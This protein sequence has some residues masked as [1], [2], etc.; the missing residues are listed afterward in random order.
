MKLQYEVC[1]SNNLRQETRKCDEYCLRYKKRSDS[2]S[3]Q[4]IAYISILLLLRQSAS[5]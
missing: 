4:F 5:S 2:N 3:H 1:E